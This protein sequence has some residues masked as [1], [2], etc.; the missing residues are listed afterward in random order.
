MLALNACG[1]DATPDGGSNSGGSGAS[2]GSGATTGSG[3]ANGNGGFG[4]DG[5]GGSGAN[6][7]GAN[8]SGA[9][10]NGGNGSGASSSGGVATGGGPAG[11]VAPNGA[12]LG[13]STTGLGGPFRFGINGGHRNP[14][15]DDAEQAEM[16]VRAGAKSQRISLP[17]THLAQ[18]GL[19]IEVGDM[20]SYAKLGL[21]GQV[22][23]LTQPVRAQSTIPDGKADWELA[24]WQPKN[25]HEPI[26]LPDGSVNPANYWAKYVFDTVTTYKEWI[27]IWEVWN[28]PD[29][30]GD[31]KVTQGWDSSAPKQSELPRFNGSIYDYVRMLRV[32]QVAARLADPDARIATG[33][34]GYPSFLRAILAYTDSPTGAVD[35][36]HAKTGAA[37]VDVVSFHHYP[38]YTAGDSNAGVAGYV[39]QLEEMKAVAKAA[40][41]TPRGWENTETGAPHLAVGGAT[42]SPEYAR[43]Y[44]VKVMLTAWADGV[45]GV[46]WFTL[47]DGA[48]GGASTDPYDFMGLYFD[49]VSLAAIGDAQLTDTGVAYATLTGLLAGAALESRDSQGSTQRLRFK[50]TA[51]KTLWVVWGAGKTETEEP[52]TVTVDGAGCT[53]YRL[54]HSKTKTTERL[55]AAANKVSLPVGPTPTL[56]VMD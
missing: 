37:Y 15:F 27:K 47:S 45:H 6:G 4:A 29:W 35:A 49:T 19:G 30:V 3:A 50:T 55:T 13:E 5:S 9:S 20:K 46:D 44:L 25:L 14:N 2:N 26:T 12:V 23:F 51:G 11:S 31:W 10:S 1:S 34:I 38:V 43:N 22:G 8:G 40:K 52:T 53:R 42:G 21:R 18:W 41:F 33:G 56:C 48:L 28:E 17:A 32:S 16:E 36:D 39:K 24:Y 7:S 54:D